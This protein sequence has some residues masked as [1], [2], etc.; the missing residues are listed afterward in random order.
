MRVA[1]ETRAEV[2][3]VLKRMIGAP[4]SSGVRAAIQQ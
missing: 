2:K 1:E 3:A 4:R